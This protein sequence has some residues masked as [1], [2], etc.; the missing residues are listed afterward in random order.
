MVVMVR[1]MAVS[2]MAMA[3]APGAEVAAAVE[4]KYLPTSNIN[5]ILTTYLKPTPLSW[6]QYFCNRNVNIGIIFLSIGNSQRWLYNTQKSKS[7]W[8]FNTQPR[9]LQSEKY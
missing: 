1:M 9:G 8:L 3:V 4:E 5:V 2:A 6:V 7:D